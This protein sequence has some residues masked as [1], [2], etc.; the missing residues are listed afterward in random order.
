MTTYM[1]NIV[2]SFLKNFSA[3][4]TIMLMDFHSLRNSGPYNSEDTTA[5][6][7]NS[8]KEMTDKNCVIELTKPLS[9]EPN[10]PRIT[11]GKIKPHT[12]TIS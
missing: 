8:I 11:L 3:D 2:A 7:P 9:S 1:H 4:E 10:S 5:P 12:T 6:T